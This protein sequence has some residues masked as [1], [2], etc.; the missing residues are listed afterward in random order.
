MKSFNQL[1]RLGRIVLA[2][3]LLL[4]VSTTAIYAQN[5]DKEKSR[6]AP[7]H[8]APPQQHHEAAPP[9][10]HEPPPQQHSA[11]QSA[12]ARTPS[13]PPSGSTPNSGRTFG[14]PSNN[15]G[16]VRP[17][18]AAPNS[19]PNNRT[20]NTGNP[21]NVG[22]TRPGGVTPNNVPNNR[23]ATP[24][25]V[26]SRGGFGSTG[27]NRPANTPGN[28]L[29][30]NNNRPGGD[31][32]V[33]RNPG[34]NNRPG[35]NPPPGGRV[36]G[37]NNT[38]GRP[39]APMVTRTSNGGMVRRAPDGQVREVRTP[40]GAVIRH[41][42]TGVRNVEVVR[43]GGRVVVARSVG[44]YVQR[45]VVVRGTTYVQRTYIVSGRP[46]VRVY[47]PYRWGGL[48]INIYRP[49]RYYPM[50]FYTYRLYAV[51]SAGALGLGMGNRDAV[52]WLLWRLVHSIPCL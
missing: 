40:S 9:Q 39:A 16:N 35:T 33:N 51:G 19:V 41:S 1:D 38:A 2:A 14:N 42:P 4:G 47:N 37:S 25:S 46:V 8:S 11:P 6:P 26:P 20:G 45:P 29:G 5:K 7:Q 49:V 52:V 3:A 10:R 22:N 31:V 32:N 43:P 48:S 34:G 44:G 30:T 12:P 36:F 24:N 18:G 28:T 23:Q 17:G 15:G 13:T 50:G 21:A 27:N